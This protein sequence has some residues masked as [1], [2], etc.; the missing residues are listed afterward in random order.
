MKNNPLLT[1]AISAYNVE[2]TLEKALASFDGLDERLVEVLVVN[3]GS[4]DGT[5]EIAKKIAKQNPLIKVI[6]QKNGGHGAT[7]NTGIK[8][9]RGKYFRLLD[10]D[11]WFD[12]KVLAKFLKRLEQE[13]ADLVLTEHM[14]VFEK[15]G[16][17][18]ET[19]D[20]DN[21][22]SNEI[23]ELEKVEF[24]KYGPTLPNLTIRTQI[25]RD[26]RLKIDEKCFYVDQELNFIAYVFAKTVVKYNLPIY[27]YRLEQD[28]QSMAVA[29]LKRNVYSHEKV[30]LRLLEW[31]G[32]FEKKMV[33]AKRAHLKNNIIVPLL[34]LQY[35]ISIQ[36]AHSREAFLSFDRKLEKYPEFYN[37]PGVA[38]SIIRLHRKTSGR[39]IF[40]DSILNRVGKAKRTK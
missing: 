35:T 11:D 9:A 5:R 24:K 40:L 7:I 14:E 33:G 22:K 25:L 8:K 16:K 6:D 31:L 27:Y 23:I 39:T 34:N 3:D 2:E 20:Y 1:V 28:G 4:T 12:K 13:T 30:C 21:L 38:G 32:D 18:V 36:Y 37:H 29:G 15:S 10:G 26:A 17:I 19:K